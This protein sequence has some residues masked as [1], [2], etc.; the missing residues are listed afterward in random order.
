MISSERAE[1]RAKLVRH[2]ISPELGRALFA[3][4]YFQCISASMHASTSLY[5]VAV[6]GRSMSVR[7]VGIILLVIKNHQIHCLLRGLHPS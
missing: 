3:F 7:L 6:I 1:V 2:L 4:W 5:T